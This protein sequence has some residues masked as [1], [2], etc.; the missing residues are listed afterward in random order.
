M[1]LSL[2]LPLI[3]LKGNFLKTSG[4]LTSPLMYS[5]CPKYT[6]LKTEKVFLSC[7]IHS[8]TRQLNGS[9][10]P[11]T[12]FFLWSISNCLR[13]CNKLRHSGTKRLSHRTFVLPKMW[14]A[15]NITLDGN[16]RRV[17]LCLLQLWWPIESSLNHFDKGGYFHVS[18]ENHM[19][20]ISHI[21][22]FGLEQKTP[23]S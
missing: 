21:L 2:L 11:S 1:D 13:L 12:L 3:N 18:K 8:F 7:F 10:W 4:D 22:V 5:E 9:R 14:L 6:E 19:S 23:P 20:H 15:Q 17:H 16:L